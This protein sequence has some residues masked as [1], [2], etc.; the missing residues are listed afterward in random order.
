[1]MI[2]TPCMTKN[3][4]H[5][6]RRGF[7][8]GLKGGVVGLAGTLL[9]AEGGVIASGRQGIAT[10]YIHPEIQ[11]EEAKHGVIFDVFDRVKKT[12]I[13]RRVAGGALNVFGSALDA[14]AIDILTNIETDTP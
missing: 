10:A 13:V 14:D 5:I 9:M 3:E 4:G 1:M 6:S 8:N 2:Y 11:S 12:G 7:L